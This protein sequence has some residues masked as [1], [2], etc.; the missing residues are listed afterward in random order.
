MKYAICPEPISDAEFEACM[1]SPICRKL[2]EK[3]KMYGFEYIPQ[4]F[5]T[6]KLSNDQEYFL[7]DVWET[8]GEMSANGL[9]ALSH[10]EPPWQ[11]ARAGFAP[12]ENCTAII[13]SVDMK[14]YYRSI[15]I[16]R[17]A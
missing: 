4:Y 17:N 16:G 14:E 15:Y 6:I 10:S 3:Y 9:E 5:G 12:N 11:K 13:S 7:E 8:Y 1:H 2:Y